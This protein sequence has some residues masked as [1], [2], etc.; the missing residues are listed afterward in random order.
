MSRCSSPPLFV[1]PHHLNCVLLDPGS[2]CASP[3]SIDGVTFGVVAWS[4]SRISAVQVGQ[5]VLDRYNRDRNS[6]NTKYC[7]SGGSK[8]DII[9]EHRDKII[10]YK[11]Q[12]PQPQDHIVSYKVTRSYHTG[13]R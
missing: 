1:H 8:I 9:P 5:T 7:S 4:T 10:S 12:S 13:L 6:P 2:G 11:Q 3:L